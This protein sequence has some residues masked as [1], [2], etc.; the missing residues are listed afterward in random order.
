MP[1][2]FRLR[3]A[4]NRSGSRLA[5]VGAQAIIAPTY[6]FDLCT[7]LGIY[8]IESPLGAGGMGE[9]YRARGTRLERAVAIKVFNAQLVDSA[10]LRAR[11]EREAKVISQLQP[12]NICVLHDVGKE[13]PI[14]Y[15]VMEFLQGKSLAERLRK[16]PLPAD[17]V[18]T[19]AIEIADALEKGHC[20]GVVHRDLKPGN[21]MLTESGAKL[22]DFGLAK[23]LGATVAS[24]PGSGTSPSV[25]AAALTQTMSPYRLRGT[26][27]DG[28]EMLWIR[29]VEF[30]PVAAFAWHRG[31]RLS[32]LFR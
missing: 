23:P 6:G 9:V 15:L 1:R 21:V 7:R 14:D 22:L 27:A 12:P 31:R 5:L 10:E 28:K 18:L 11:F 8:E 4:T 29:P 20:A 16:A 26:S 17:Q 25:F 30:R 13:G 3:L 24:K 19:I 2:R 32:V